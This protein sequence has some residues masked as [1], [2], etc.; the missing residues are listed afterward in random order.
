VKLATVAF[1]GGEPQPAVVVDDDRPVPLADAFQRAGMFPDSAP[2]SMRELIGRFPAMA[3]AL[4]RAADAAA[5][6]SDAPN[7]IEWHPPLP[8]PSKILGCAINN[9][10]LN[11]LATVHPANPPFFV[12][13]PSSLIGHGQPIVIRPDYGLTHPEGELAVVIG[14]RSKHLEP[15]EV[16]DAIFG[17]TIMND[18]T[19]ITLK[20]E[21]T[22]VFPRPGIEPA[23]P[24][25]EHGDMH[26]VYHARSKGTDGFGPCGPWIV[27]ADEI[28]GPDDL[29]VNVFMGNELCS[30]DS[31]ANLR[32]SVAEVIAWLSRYVTLEPGDIVHMGTAARGKYALREL[33]F[34]AWDGPCTVEISGIGRLS[35]PIVRL[36]VSGQPV[37]GRP[38]T[39][40][41]PWPPRIAAGAPR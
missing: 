12:K 41:E 34:Q 9:A 29:A 13:L 28:A 40:A 8:D 15:A 1:S 16:A 22:Y 25:F 37:P 14:R 24:G 3:S 18:V 23:P 21:D 33:D 26:L 39:E 38:R 35:N 7:A 2:R 11:D 19:S 32:F 27:T 4:R 20:G 36:D 6:P 5:S 17:Y 10:A 31:T 30:S